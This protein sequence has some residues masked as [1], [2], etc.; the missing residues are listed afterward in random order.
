M[1]TFIPASGLM[2]VSSA[3][4]RLQ[5]TVRRWFTSG[6]MQ[7]KN[8]SNARLVTENFELE[9]H[10]KSK[11]LPD[12]D[13]R[14]YFPCPKLNSYY[15]FLKHNR[16]HRTNAEIFTSDYCQ[17]PFKKKETL[18]QHIQVH[19]GRKHKCTCCRKAF[20]FKNSRILHE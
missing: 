14:R 11:H 17:K 7:V 3:T 4:K 10:K 12:A 2:N 16:K 5:H 19:S 1:R 13:P 8:G 20:T 6:C 18:R 9:N 15:H